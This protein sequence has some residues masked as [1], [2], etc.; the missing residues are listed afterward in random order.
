MFF[1]V[2]N[3]KLDF[4]TRGYRAREILPLLG[5]LF[6]FIFFIVMTLLELPEP[7]LELLDVTLVLPGERL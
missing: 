7:L 3:R 5:F 1:L 4:R 6:V 2:E